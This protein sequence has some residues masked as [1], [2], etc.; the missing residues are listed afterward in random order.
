MEVFKKRGSMTKF[1]IL[2]EIS[3]QEPHLKQK[4]LADRLGIT[5]QAVSENIKSL[6]DEGYIT[7][8]EGRSPYKITQEGIK[9][10]KRDAITLRKYSDSVLEIM[11]HYQ[12]IWPAIA[13]E[14]IEKGDKVGI[15]M[16]KGLLY[17]SHKEQSANAIAI[18]PAKTGEDV[19]LGELTGLIDLKVGKVLIITIPTIKEGG[20]AVTDLDLIESI[21]KN[22]FKEWGENDQ[23]DKVAVIGTVSHAITNKLNLPIDIE[24]AVAASTASAARKG[25]N[26]MALSVGNMTK[27]FI[28][29]VEKEDVNYNV[30]NGK[31]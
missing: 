18:S 11:D 23:I 22:G 19:A 2:S 4:D 17:A 27:S 6:I 30:I 5:V 20:S 26:V 31:L 25:L 21:Y 15:F 8:K 14:D 3:K 28:K 29:E 10:V 1:Q 7:Y 9:K 24:F 12:S 16:E 13:K